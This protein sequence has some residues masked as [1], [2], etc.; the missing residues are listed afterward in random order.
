MIDNFINLQKTDFV[1][2]EVFV[3]IITVV[4]YWT[5]FMGG[6]KKWSDCVKKTWGSRWYYT[7]PL[8]QP[9]SLKIIMTIVLIA[10]IGGGYGVV[11]NKIQNF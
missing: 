1:I 3:L 9:L 5:L 2:Y 4:W 8:V 10:T 6:A 7:Q 11:L